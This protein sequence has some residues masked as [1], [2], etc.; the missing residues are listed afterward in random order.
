[1]NVGGKESSEC[2]LKKK[3]KLEEIPGEDYGCMEC[4]GRVRKAM[5]KRNGNFLKVL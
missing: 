5:W 3:E 1:M 2:E 4:S